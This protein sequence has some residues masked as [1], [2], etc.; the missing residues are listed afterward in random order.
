MA[1]SRL[2]EQME[3]VFG[4]DAGGGAADQLARFA[5]A[6]FDGAFVALQASRK[7]H[8]RPPVGR[9]SA[10]TPISSTNPIA[11]PKARLPSGGAGP[12]I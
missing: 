3:I 6:A 7:V 9:G 2:R 12:G 8:L 4:V 10:S 1:L 11:K 5:L